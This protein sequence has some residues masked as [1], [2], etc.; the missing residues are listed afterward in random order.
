M[1][2]ARAFCAGLPWNGTWPVWPRLSR[3][4]IKPRPR[5][6]PI[7]PSPPSPNNRTKPRLHT[8][9]PNV[10]PTLNSQSPGRKNFRARSEL[11]R[12]ILGPGTTNH[13][14]FD[15]VTLLQKGRVGEGFE[16]V[17]AWGIGRTGA[18]IV[19]QHPISVPLELLRQ[20]EPGRFLGNVSVRLVSQAQNGN[21]GFRVGQALDLLK[22]IQIG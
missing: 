22:K 21:G 11:Y 20:N 3:K 15:V 6:R 9:P 14:Q 7:L 5:R 1:A 17:Q 2:C 16:L 8:V 4:S 18:A 19:H 13:R 12:A 10:S